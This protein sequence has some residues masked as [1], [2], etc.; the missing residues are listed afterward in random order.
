L[1]FEH[2]CP[3]CNSRKAP[4][5]QYACDECI[6]ASKY[7]AANVGS[8]PTRHHPTNRAAILKTERDY[9]GCGEQ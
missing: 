7:L 4:M 5:G 6:N 8:L 1:Y 3:R 9:E 2:W